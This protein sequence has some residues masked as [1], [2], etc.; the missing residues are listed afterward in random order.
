MPKHKALPP[1]AELMDAFEYDPETGLFVHARYKCGRAL[2]G[3]PAGFL[4]PKGYVHIQHKR[5]IYKAHRMA[6]VFITGEDPDHLQVDHI[7][8][9][10]SNNRA[11]NLRLATAQQNRLN[12]KIKGY[13]K[14]GDKYRAQRWVDGH[15][16]HLG[17][18][19]TPEA[20]TAA[21]QQLDLT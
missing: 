1:L 19:D 2:K 17:M 18:H 12:T 8:R 16:I 11:A 6:W 10:R 7:D 9:N 20:A 21:Y 14:I 13:T 3:A 15:M 4:H 5:V